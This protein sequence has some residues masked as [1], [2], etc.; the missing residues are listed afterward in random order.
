MSYE[1]SPSHKAPKLGFVIP[2]LINFKGCVELIASIK[3]EY[4]F[5]IYLEEQWR[6]N[7]PLAKA[8]ND[9]FD[10]AVAGGCEFVFI[11]NDDIL[12]DQNAVDNLVR[13]MIRLD[14][15]NDRVVLVSSNNIIG[16]L[17]DPYHVLAH[18]QEYAIPPNISD[19]PNYSCFMVR[20]DFMDKVGRFDENFVPAWFE[21]NDSHRRIELL[22]YR[23][24]CTTASSCVHF[25]GVSTAMISNPS[26]EKSRQY[27][28]KKWGDLPEGH[29]GREIYE[30]PYN[31]PELSAKEWIA[32][33]G[34]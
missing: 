10:R 24:I 3:T 2:C 20:K 30:H 1:V 17:S 13:E 16:E 29:G 8:W 6:A 26:S 33:Y 21:D 12:F 23:A 18:T 25:G 19:H 31:N 15:N 32:H 4:P 9:G 14:N 11:L 34:A 27:Y 28:V 5:E 22:G 7:K